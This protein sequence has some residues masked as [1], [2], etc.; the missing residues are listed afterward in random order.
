M[1]QGFWS[2]LTLLKTSDKTSFTDCL[3]V[4][5]LLCSEM[6]YLVLP[7][8]VSIATRKYYVIQLQCNII[9]FDRIMWYR[10]NTN[11]IQHNTIQYNT[12]KYTII[13]FVLCFFSGPSFKVGL[14]SLGRFW[15]QWWISASVG[16][17][18]MVPR[19]LTRWLVPG[20]L[21]CVSTQK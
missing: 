11:T 17:T 15:P 2:L 10:C 8:T 12:I 6:V 20:T 5:G 14:F 9:W 4:F 1:S 18:L 19:H 16:Q 21:K 3:F 13:Y 7:S